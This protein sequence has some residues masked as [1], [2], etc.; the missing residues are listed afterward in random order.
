MNADAAAFEI[1]S[2]DWPIGIR[3]DSRLLAV[4]LGAS[5]QKH[6]AGLDEG[7]FCGLNEA[8]YK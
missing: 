5:G 6:V 7:D 1:A 4:P 8:T 3:V 2:R